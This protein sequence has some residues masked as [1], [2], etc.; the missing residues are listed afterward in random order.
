ML[1]EYI[2]PCGILH[3]MNSEHGACFM[4]QNFPDVLKAVKIKFQTH[5]LYY[6]QSSGKVEAKQNLQ[7]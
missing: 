3:N 2:F 5:I 7:H 4:R 6:P 1:Q